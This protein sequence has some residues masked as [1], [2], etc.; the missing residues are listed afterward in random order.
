MRWVYYFKAQAQTNNTHK[1]DDSELWH[2]RLGHSS[3]KIVSFL[4]GIS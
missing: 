1:L 4:P 2:R 3:N